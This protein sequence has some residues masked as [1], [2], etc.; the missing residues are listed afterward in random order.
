MEYYLA[1]K[2]DDI[3]NFAGKW[4]ELEDII[5]DEVTQNPKD[6][7]DMPSLISGY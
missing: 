6:M 4:I 5:Q 3:M 7:H 2:N 1:S